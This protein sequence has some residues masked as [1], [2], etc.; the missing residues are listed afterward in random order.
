MTT[1][2]VAMATYNGARFLKK[3]LE[4][5]VTQIRK[6]D[7]L[8]VTDDGSTD[9]TI[10]LLERF[11]LTAPFPVRIYRNPAQLGYR[12][13]FMHCANLCSGD[14]IAFSDQD[15]IWLP[16]KLARQCER[17]AE[18]DVLLST[19]YVLLVNDEGESLGRTYCRYRLPQRF[20]T[21]NA[22]PFCFNA[23]FTLA[24][25]RELLR[26]SQYW[27][28]SVDENFPEHRMAHD[29]WFCFLG[30]ALG[31]VYCDRT[32]LAHYRQH[33]D[34]IFGAHAKNS[35]VG[36]IES[37]LTARAADYARKALGAAN[38]RDQ[39]GHMANHLDSSLRSRLE[40]T[41]RFYDN[42]EAALARRSRLFETKSYGGRLGLLLAAFMS[43]DYL[44]DSRRH[45]GLRS[46]ARDLRIL[47]Q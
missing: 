19:H 7:E 15:D 13:N 36:A 5:F 38:R 2:S 44:G 1:L 33:T 22:P 41:R 27:P 26:F 8:I 31:I 40:Y 16:E 43:G 17:L 20:T 29:Q 23:G 34:N 47:L 30:S 28:A 39:I 4:S 18:P 6:P 3:Q 21:R 9:S 32:V 24:F 11:A 10:T 46:A 45:F 25:R 14:I 12:A 37:P 42:Y 35:K